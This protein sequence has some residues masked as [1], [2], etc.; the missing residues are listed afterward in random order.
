MTDITIHQ[1]AE[2][3]QQ[4]HSLIMD[5]LEKANGRCPT[6]LVDLITIACDLSGEIRESLEEA[7]K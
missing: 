1:A 5:I 3:A 4:A 6:E 2:K 7:T